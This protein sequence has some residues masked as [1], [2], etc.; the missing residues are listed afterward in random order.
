[1]WDKAE[2]YIP[3]LA[4]HVHRLADDKHGNPTG[5]VHLACYDFKAMAEITFVD[6]WQVVDQPRSVKWDKIAS[7]LSGVA[8]GFFPDGHGFQ[9][10]PHVKVKCSPNKILQGHNVFGSEDIKPGVLQML[11]MF[12]QAFP[13]IA[14]H[15]DWDYAEMCWVDST[16]SAAP[17]SRFYQDTI[18]RALQP[19]SARNRNLDLR[20]DGYIAI[21]GG[22]DRSRLKVYLKDQELQADMA[23]AKRGGETCRFQVLSDIRLQDFAKGRTRFEASTLKRKFL[24]LGIPTKLNDFFKFHD[25]FEETHGEP[26]CRY[27]WRLGFDPLFKQLEGQTMKHV[28]DNSVREQID[29]KFIKIKDNGKSCKRK[30]NS[31]FNTYRQIKSEGYERLVKENNS[32]FYRN[33]NC[34][35]ECGLSRAFLK[36]LDPHKPNTNVIPLIQLIKVDFSNQRPDWYEEPVASFDDPRRHLRLIA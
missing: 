15:L 16:Y 9:G 33:V 24:Q 18:L 21:G 3:F 12:K 35:L 22:S 7:S 1:M 31:V 29:S 14:D 23:K 34:L 17:L 30:A 13:L 36:S 28:D 6:G 8:V 5:F 4:E 10:W 26:L 19:L 11:A 20:Y 27:L 2:V 32:A 25:W